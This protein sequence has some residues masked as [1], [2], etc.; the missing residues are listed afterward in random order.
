M[1]CLD[2]RRDDL[3]MGGKIRIASVQ[4]D[5][6]PPGSFNG[7]DAVGR[8]YGGRLHDLL[9]LTIQSHLEMKDTTKLLLNSNFYFN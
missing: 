5:D 7:Q 4:G 9:E 2:T 6:R 8:R 3:R 1:Q